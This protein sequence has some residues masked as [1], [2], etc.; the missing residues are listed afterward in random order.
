MMISI[1]MLSSLGIGS[2][3]QQ[4]YISQSR[5]TGGTPRAALIDELSVTNPDPSFIKNMTKMLSSSGYNVDYY[6]P[7]D[8]TVDL[9]RTLPLQSYAIVIIRSHTAS[10]QSIITS[11]PYSSSQYV[12]EQV[13]NEVGSAELMGSTMTYFSISASFVRDAIQGNF[14]G[15]IV[16]AMGCATFQGRPDMA[17]AF[18]KKGAS[19][20]VGWD[21]TVSP[22]HT[23]SATQ[24]LLWSLVHGKGVREAVGDVGGPDPTYGGHMTYLDAASVSHDQFVN[25]L[26]SVET[27]ALV[28]CF[29]ILAPATILLIPRLASR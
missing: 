15:A 27:L 11:Q 12:Y 9:F 25:E 22:Q 2:W 19:V 29:L 7:K 4:T 18:I 14:H 17:N 6:G 16:I 23:D 8:V 24:D 20:F 13:V 1:M 26:A 10:S 28:L 3:I 21:G 5:A